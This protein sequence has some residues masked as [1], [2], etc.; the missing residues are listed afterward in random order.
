MKKLILASALTMSLC[1]LGAFADP[2]TGYI[3]E[4]HCGAAHSSVSD[5]NTKCV[6]KCL[7]GGSDPVL[8]SDGKVIKIAADSKDKAAAMAGKEV[9]IDGTMDGDMLKISSIE[10]AK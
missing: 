1:S 2:M 9:K 4:S 5:A 6:E 3:S 10:E 8:V 7:K